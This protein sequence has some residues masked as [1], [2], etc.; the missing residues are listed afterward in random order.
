MNVWLDF[1]VHFDFFDEFT[2]QGTRLYPHKQEN[3]V[4][5]VPNYQREQS[6]LW[7]TFATSPLFSIWCSTITMFTVVRYLLQKIHG[8]HRVPFDRIA[9]ETCGLSFGWVIVASASSRAE[10][11]LNIFISMFAILSGIFFSGLLLQQFAFTQQVPLI[12]TFED[13]KAMQRMTIMIPMGLEVN[14]DMWNPNQ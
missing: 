5:I 10:R 11:L 4:L 14:Q 6:A 7:H 8:R 9:Y 1:S 12:N 2:P 13:L 3:F